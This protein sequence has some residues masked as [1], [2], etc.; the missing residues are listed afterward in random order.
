MPSSPR[1]SSR[2][3]PTGL[4]SISVISALLSPLVIAPTTFGGINLVVL[5]R[6]LFLKPVQEDHVATIHPKYDP[7]LYFALADRRADLTQP[8]ADR[9]A[10]RHS[11]RPAEFYSRNILTHGLSILRRKFQ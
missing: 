6:R 3:S 2:V 7:R 10:Y 5:L 8:R 4:L 1:N 11:D 9:T